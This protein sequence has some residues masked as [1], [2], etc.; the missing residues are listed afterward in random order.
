ML[1][2][3]LVSGCNHRTSVNAFIVTTKKSKQWNE[4][5]QIIGRFRPDPANKAARVILVFFLQLTISKTCF[6]VE[7]AHYRDIKSSVSSR[8]HHFASV[9]NN[10]NKVGTVST[11]LS[12][13]KT[14]TFNSNHVQNL[15]ADYARDPYTG[16]KERSVSNRNNLRRSFCQW[17]RSIKSGEKNTTNLTKREWL[18]HPAR[19]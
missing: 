10:R 16:E 1:D 11:I 7:L 8:M 13:C 2:I 18:S 5:A 14:T 3:F 15:F 4:T 9:N 12:N 6:R 17:K 19:F